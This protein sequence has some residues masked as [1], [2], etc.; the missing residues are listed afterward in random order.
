M[1]RSSNADK[2][3]KFRCA[4]VDADEK[5]KEQA[6]RLAAVKKQAKKRVGF[7]SGRPSCTHHS[8]SHADR[9]WIDRPS[10]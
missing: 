3:K 6:D 2:Q 9:T 4:M 10:N 5:S 8:I 1:Y 7:H